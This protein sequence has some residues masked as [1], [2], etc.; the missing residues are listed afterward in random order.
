[1]TRSLIDLVE[2]SHESEGSDKDVW[3]GGGRDPDARPRL[4]FNRWEAATSVLF[5]SPVPA[6]LKTDNDD[7]SLKF[8]KVPYLTL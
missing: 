4:L 7:D 5:R 8:Q 2:G 1:M 6:P 3:E